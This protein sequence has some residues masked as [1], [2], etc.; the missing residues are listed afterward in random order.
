MLIKI[1]IHFVALDKYWYSEAKNHTKK[2]VLINWNNLTLN[3]SSNNLLKKMHLPDSKDFHGKRRV[4][5]L[6]MWKWI[7]ANYTGNDA[8]LILPIPSFHENPKNLTITLFLARYYQQKFKVLTLIFFLHLFWIIPS[9]FNIIFI[10]TIMKNACK[11]LPSICFGLKRYIKIFCA[12]FMI[13][14]VNLSHFWTGIG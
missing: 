3:F 12:E 14:I 11:Q 13:Y 2:F 7:P 1:L 5:Y 4:A 6:S 9:V 8:L 10:C